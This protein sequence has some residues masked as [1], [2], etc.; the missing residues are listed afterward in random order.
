LFGAY[1]QLVTAG[2]MNRLRKMGDRSVE[3]ISRRGLPQPLIDRFT[4]KRTAVLDP[5]TSA[6]WKENWYYPSP[7]MHEDAADALEPI[8]RAVVAECGDGR[9]SEARCGTSS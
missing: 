9:V 2:M 7:E 4:G 1:P 3:C 8:C 6:P 5:W